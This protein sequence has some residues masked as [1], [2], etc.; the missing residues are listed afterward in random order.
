MTSPSVAEPVRPVCFSALRAHGFLTKDIRH[1]IIDGRRRLAMTV[2]A[3]ARAAGV[4]RAAVQQWE[5]L[6]GTAPNGAHRPA[7]ARLLEMSLDQAAPFNRGPR[8]PA[9]GPT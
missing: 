8:P 3:F 2:S 5:R 4:T 6:G 9:V 1:L 7:V